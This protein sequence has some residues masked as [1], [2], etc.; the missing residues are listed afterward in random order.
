VLN[1]LDI[2]M[3]NKIKMLF[4]SHRSYNYLVCIFSFIFIF[5]TL[6]VQ[7][8][9]VN[10]KQL[11]YARKYKYAAI[12]EMKSHKIPASITLAQ[13]ILESGCG[14]SVLAVNT[15]NH[16]GIKC[17]KGWTGETYRYDDDAPQ[18]CFRKYAS[19]QD[20]YEDH[21]YFLTS[22]ERYS[23]LFK[24]KITDYKGWAHGLKKAGYATNPR[25]AYSLIKII[26]DNRLY[27]YDLVALGKMTIEEA[28]AFYDLYID[29]D[30]PVV[31]LEKDIIE[32]V[33]SLAGYE[34]EIEEHHHLSQDNDISGSGFHNTEYFG[35][36]GCNILKNAYYI[37]RTNGRDIYLNNDILFTLSKADETIEDI[38]YSLDISPRYLRKY[39]DLPRKNYLA[40]N[41]II[42]LENKNFRSDMKPYIVKTEGET[43]WT[44]SQCFAIHAKRLLN[45]NNIPKSKVNE[46]LRVGTV[47][48]FN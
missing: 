11:R 19:V 47:V 32:E 22:R 5:Q 42:Y 1:F 29:P 12:A 33:G 6:N 15:N 46:K 9:E 34:L 21:S 10:E 45:K 24:L 3:N 39:N 2:V 27:N 36:C 17:H 28:E 7:A 14:E 35:N 23:D 44:I 43:I 18:E 4:N 8:Q 41:T 26:E 13:G 30:K 40:E 48:K 25:Y 37:K 31:T 16:F 20:S 38:A